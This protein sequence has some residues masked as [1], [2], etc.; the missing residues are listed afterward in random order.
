MVGT[1]AGF[2]WVPGLKQWFWRTGGD[3]PKVVEF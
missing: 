2:M 3:L 1:G